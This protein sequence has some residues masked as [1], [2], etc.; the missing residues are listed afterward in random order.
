MPL[1]IERVI[2]IAVACCGV[3]VDFLLR[4]VGTTSTLNLNR[5]VRG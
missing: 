3:L 1:L 5:L 2:L 4:H